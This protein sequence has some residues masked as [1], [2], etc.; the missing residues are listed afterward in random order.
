MSS[1]TN[2]FLH[3]SLIDQNKI[4]FLSYLTQHSV[5]DLSSPKAKSVFF[6]ILHSGKPLFLQNVMSNN[7]RQLLRYYLLYCDRVVVKA[8]R[9]KH[10]ATFGRGRYTIARIVSY[11]TSEIGLQ[12]LKSPLKTSSGDNVENKLQSSCWEIVSQIEDSISFAKDHILHHNILTS[13]NTSD[14][15]ID[16]YK[17]KLTKLD[18][19]YFK[20]NALL[21]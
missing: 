14:Y 21:N 17:I 9:Q 20:N 19:L 18:I 1:F 7:G 16:F 4:L 12:L 2:N 11:K 6:L 5:S 10:Y 13:A 3:S 8:D 15:D